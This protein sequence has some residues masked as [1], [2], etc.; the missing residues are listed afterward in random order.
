M[1]PTLGSNICIKLICWLYIKFRH[2]GGLQTYIYQHFF[3][4]QKQLWLPVLLRKVETGHCQL[5]N[6]MVLVTCG[7]T[8]SLPAPK[9]NQQQECYSSTH[10]SKSN[11][12][13]Y[14]TAGGFSG[15]HPIQFL[16]FYC[17]SSSTFHNF[18]ASDELYSYIRLYVH[19]TV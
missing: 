12:T 18:C 5:K 1:R 15:H 4:L 17:N 3:L 10:N 13:K 14:H 16:L 11:L 8:A 7:N 2:A 6:H 19:C 9:R